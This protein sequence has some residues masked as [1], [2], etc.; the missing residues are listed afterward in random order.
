MNQPGIVISEESEWSK[1]QGSQANAWIYFVHERNGGVRMCEEN[2]VS[3]LLL[4]YKGRM[5]I[6]IVREHV[7]VTC[8]R[9]YDH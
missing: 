1:L 2:V 6:I 9:P 4:Y 3:A 8:E 5:N 7:N